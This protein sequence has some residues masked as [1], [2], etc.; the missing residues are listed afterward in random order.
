MRKTTL[1]EMREKLANSPLFQSTLLVGSAPY[2]QD[3]A[4]LCDITGETPETVCNFIMQQPH[5]FQA[6]RNMIMAGA[7]LASYRDGQI[8]K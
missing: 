2:A 6:C 7:D 8:V 4:H 1:I 3:I 5:G